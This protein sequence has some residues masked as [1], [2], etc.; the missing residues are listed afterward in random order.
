MSALPKPSFP[1]K[2]APRRQRLKKRRK[3]VAGY[4]PKANNQQKIARSQP[5]NHPTQLPQGKA[6]PTNLQVLMLLQRTSF[7]IAL[8][9][10]AT[11]MGLYVSTVQI[12]QQWSQEYENLEKLQR[13]ERELTT[14]NESLR[15]HIAR[16]AARENSELSILA[17][18][19]A[20]FIAPAKSITETTVEPSTKE[21]EIVKFKHSSAGY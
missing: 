1:V 16:Q 8:V 2:A 17:P 11:S 12:P 5:A 7:G 19:D 15:Y 4:H 21:A 10:L 20:V 9:S 13:Q 6:L 3:V 14:I 18:Q